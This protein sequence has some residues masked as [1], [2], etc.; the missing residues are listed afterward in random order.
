M[1]RGCVRILAALAAVAVVVAYLVHRFAG[2]GD[3]API[4]LAVVGPMTG[5]NPENGRAFV[6]GVRLLTDDLNRRGGVNGRRLV[7]DVY[8]DGNDAAKARAAA[9]Q[10]VAD[11]RAVA[12]V[13]HN[14]SDCSKAGGEVYQA[15]G[16]AAITP[17]S[18]AP[19]VTEG[20]DWYF[21]TIFSD[22]LEGSF[23]ASYAARVFKATSIATIHERGTW[24]DGLVRIVR[25]DCDA[26]GV[27]A[28][29]GWSFDP[30][31][32]TLEHDL[33]G[34]VD[35]LVTSG[36]R[37]VLVLGV[38]AGAGVPLVRIL[39]ERGVENVI[40]TPSSLV[41]QAFVGG[42]AELLAERNNPGY[43]TNGIYV[44]SPLLLDSV[45]EDGQELRRAYQAR[46]DGRDPDWRAVFAHDAALL[47]V[48]AVKATAASGSAATLAADRRAI[49]DWLAGL[50]QVDVAVKG[51]TGFNY[52]NANGD[53]MK[54]VFLGQYSGRNIVSART[55][56]QDV[57]NIRA[58]PDLA[59]EAAAG[60][61]LMVNGRPMYGTEVVYV[62]LRLDTVGAV[63]LSAG[64]CQL[65]FDLWFRWG[66]QTAPTDIQFL[67]AVG[68]LELGEPIEE[69]VIGD[70]SYRRYRVSGTFKLDYLPSDSFERHTIGPAFVHRRLTRNNLVY[71]V[72]VVGMDLV[73]GAAFRRQLDRDAVLATVSGWRTVDAQLFQRDLE[74][75]TQGDPRLL[76]GT[77]SG[78]R[79]SS[80]AA[81]IT[82]E[83]ERLAIRRRIA[84]DTSLPLTVAGFLVI[85]AL[86]VAG[87]TKAAERFAQPLW[88][89]NLA[90][91]T[92]VLLAGEVVLVDGMIERLARYH[93]EQITRLF[94]ILWWVVPTVYLILAL[95]VFVWRPL[96]RSASQRIPNIVRRFVAFVLLLLCF[97]AIIAFV[98]DQRIT[99]LLA[100]SGVI[101]MIIGLAIQIN[102]S[103]IFSG[104]ALNL[105]RPFRVGDW[106]KVAG[107]DEAKVLDMTWRSTRL[108]LRDN[109]VLAVPNSI[110]AESQVVNFH[111]PD[112][113]Y[114]VWIYFHVD[115][116]CD[117][118]RVIKV[119]TDAMLS[120]PTV[121]R[122]PAPGCRF[123]GYTDWSG[124]FV[125]VPLFSGYGKKNV[126]RGAIMTHLWREL[127]RAGIRQAVRTH[128]TY[129]LRG[130]K[131][132]GVRSARPIDILRSVEIFQ[133]LSDEAKAYITEQMTPHTFAP[134]QVVVEQ[135]A[136]GDSL[137]IIVEGTVGVWVRLAS[138]ETLEVDRM[139][140]GSFFGEMA[141]LTGEARTASIKAVS[142]THVF[143]VKRDHLAPLIE[144]QPEMSVI[145]T[146]ELTR[147]TINRETKKSAHEAGKI[148]REALFSRLFNKMQAFFG[149]SDGKGGGGA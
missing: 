87:Q 82:I 136:A 121:L 80:F 107:F 117:P 108:L 138:G 75:G 42:F 33:A 115:P 73:D 132:M 70:L 4:H 124:E 139:G 135:G 72:D 104:I 112:D 47:V 95:E 98:Y 27:D 2:D 147:R 44:S 130:D 149:L 125:A 74:R 10:V 58:V 79:F 46:Y 109:T 114:E 51:A 23:I 17:S 110:A 54:P 140:A 81:K 18:T 96:E 7:V 142:E 119:A 38:R 13:G 32:P 65:D 3:L 105:E 22:S 100:T 52:F 128:E 103:N 76:E 28:S 30:A 34:V 14:Y 106:I 93:L 31:S 15:A 57:P 55:Q 116:A 146:E 120:H 59:A 11:G 16:I 12:V 97:F 148:D 41:S 99:S 25:D 9:E 90:A 66:G 48:E 20:N 39:R 78:L 84:P 19:S 92:T 24:G 43:Y 69:S 53:S 102:I 56:F 49:R 8:D 1:N 37:G 127:H 134:G 64:T 6:E 94:D 71:V 113:S 89:L 129:L 144:R 45:D 63:D 143:E 86:L 50:D 101:A 123:I 131:A 62:G 141:L 126:F 88:L 21:R 111:Q 133:P 40:L 145:L 61:I 68:A 5:Q 60:R 118:S 29:Q 36:H 26:L 83:R 35:Q 85:L 77:A 137:F 122:D 91:G 67:N